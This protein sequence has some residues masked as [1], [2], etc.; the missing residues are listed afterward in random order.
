MLR[1]YKLMTAWLTE[2][3]SYRQ[4]GQH[5][6]GTTPSVN[7]INLIIDDLSDALRVYK[8]PWSKFVLENLAGD[9]S[10]THDVK[11]G[12]LAFYR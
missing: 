6:F 3:L 2:F 9:G 8:F 5:L 10:R 1:N 7:Q 4:L 11:L 12:K